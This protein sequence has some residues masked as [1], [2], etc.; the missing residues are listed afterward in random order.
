[1][2]Q[3]SLHIGHPAAHPDFLVMGLANIVGCGVVVDL[4]DVAHGIILG[5][6][7]ATEIAV[8]ALK[9]HHRS[10]VSASCVA[11]AIPGT[12]AEEEIHDEP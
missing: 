9:L 4:R 6:S 11:C 12:I 2:Q 5:Y 1:M 7:I 10:R 3:R 8:R